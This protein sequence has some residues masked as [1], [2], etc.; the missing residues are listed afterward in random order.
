MIYT[1]TDN[2]NKIIGCVDTKRIVSFVYDGTSP[3]GDPRYILMLDWGHTLTVS[4]L[5]MQ[6]I[7]SAMQ[8]AEG[9]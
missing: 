8:K 1:I 5:D 9:V 3:D 6:H 4:A 2:V 7:L